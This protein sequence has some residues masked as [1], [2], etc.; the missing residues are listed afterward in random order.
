ML[1]YSMAPHFLHIEPLRR[2]LISFNFA[3]KMSLILFIST[4]DKIWV[5]RIWD[6]SLAKS[7]AMIKQEF[8]VSSK[9]QIVQ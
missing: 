4:S 9:I 1:L 8:I 7:I 5:I 6:D 2:Q 3:F